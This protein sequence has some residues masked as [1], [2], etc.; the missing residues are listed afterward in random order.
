MRLVRL[1]L[2]RLAASLPGLAIIVIGL[3]LVLELAPGD[4]VDA[5]MSQ[6]GSSDDAL[7]K[8]LREY[9]GLDRTVTVR[10]VAYLWRLVHLDLG[11]SV[12]FGMPV[13]N[14]I[15]QRMPVTLA[16]MSCALLIAFAL[17][18][19]I[20]ILAARRVNGWPDTLISTLGL[21]FYA[22][23][24]FWFGLMGILLFAVKLQ[25][26]P[27]GGLT[28]LSANHSGIRFILDAAVHLILPVATLAL[29]YL[30][31]Y[32]RI[33]RASMLEVLTL[34][35][36]RTARAKG[37]RESAVLIRHALRNALPPLVTIIGLQV[38]SMLGGAVVVESVFSLPG[39]GRLAYEAVVS[40]D[41]NLLLGIVFMSSILVIIVNFVVDMLYAWLDPRIDATV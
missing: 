31:I 16:L 3:F 35:F 25:W 6:M 40:R 18:S 36:V 4:S 32:L 14:L 9:Y 27:A 17:G 12:Q 28:D 26:L 41:L 30:A 2:N 24:S 7:A 23:P 21:I 13:A 11:T 8:T 10:M 34:D 5:L 22:T 39:L 19:A 1:A 37:V 20:G 29:I 33:M 38:G 15:F